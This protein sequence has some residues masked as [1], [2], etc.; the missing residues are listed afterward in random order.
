M[1]ETKERNKNNLQVH[2]IDK[3]FYLFK[4]HQFSPLFFGLYNFERKDDRFGW[5][6]GHL[7]K[8]Y[9]EVKL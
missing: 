1:N 2:Y 3:K 7:R 9:K 8:I 6:A 4:G 5:C